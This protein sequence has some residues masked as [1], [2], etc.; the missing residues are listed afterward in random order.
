MAVFR[1]SLVLVIAM[2]GLSW[3]AAEA[4]EVSGLY[5]VEVPLEDGDR[6]AAFRDALGRVLVRVTG[7]R[8]AASAPGVAPLLDAASSYVQQ[9]R[10]P[11]SETL[12][13]SFDG[14]ALEQAL[15]E[16]GQPLWGRDRPA[17]LL[18]LAADA[19][20]GTRFVVP[21]EPETGPEEALKAQ[22]EA[23]AERRGLPL[24]FP[25]MDAEDRSRASFAEVWGGF[26]DAIAEAS[27]RYGPE[28]VLVG[29]VSAGDPARGRWVLYT[30]DGTERWVAGPAE[31]VDRVA[32]QFANRL[33]VVSSGSGSVVEVQVRGVT[34]VEDY[35]RVVSFLEGLTAVQAMDL[36]RLEGSTLFFRASLHGDRSA[37]DQAVRLGGVLRPADRDPGQ[38]GLVYRLAP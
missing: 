22:M 2:V 35:G 12:W 4:A 36:D 1:V 19:G 14:R 26:E 16:L 23:A 8:D 17:V 28:A 15:I 20:G 24:V 34:S 25:L 18:W 6:D 29:R 30:P 5:A 11:T 33:A 38:G 21:A 13:V 9:F 31:S 7:R 10:N 3:P 37:F 32:D 27:A